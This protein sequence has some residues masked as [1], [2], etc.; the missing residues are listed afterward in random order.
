[1]TM[2]TNQRLSSRR[3]LSIQTGS[4]VMVTELGDFYANEDMSAFG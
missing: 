4:R 2:S 1:M 3:L